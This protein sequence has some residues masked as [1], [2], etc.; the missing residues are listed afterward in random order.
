M[1]KF[2]EK[3]YENGYNGLNPYL[4][5]I[6]GLLKFVV[7]KIQYFLNNFKSEHELEFTEHSNDVRNFPPS[8]RN[9]RALYSL[10]KMWIFGVVI[11][12]LFLFIDLLLLFC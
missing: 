7:K 5:T 11:D 12:L 3:F 4:I 10:G 2:N 6:I 9:F 1:N 8:R